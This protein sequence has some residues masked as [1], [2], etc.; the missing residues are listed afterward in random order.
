MLYVN[1]II[2]PLYD[3]LCW[4]A[5]NWYYPQEASP[6]QTR[7]RHGSQIIYKLDSMLVYIN[8]EA[9]YLISKKLQ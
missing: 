9:R 5:V 2:F 4:L 8:T 7:F 1:A 3:L 6:C